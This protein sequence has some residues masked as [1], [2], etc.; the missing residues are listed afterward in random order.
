MLNRVT[1]LGLT[2]TAGDAEL[3]EIDAFFR[4]HGVRYAVALSP[5]APTEIGGR[6][7]ARGFE[8]GYAWAKFRRGVEDPE[9]VPTELRVEA[10]TDGVLFGAVVTAAYEMPATGAAWFA[11]LPEREGWHC[12]VAFDGDEPAGAG[13]LFVRGSV[14]WLGVAG[15]APEH[16]RKGAQNAIMATRIRRGRELGVT[17]LTTETGE[18]V[19]DRPSN[20]YRNILRT[21]FELRYVR[22]NLVS[23]DRPAATGPVDASPRPTSR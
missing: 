2:G 22:P 6:L 15:T 4:L 21:G 8:Y 12:F 11:S 14:G 9:P 3:D 13:A 16:R 10:V 18:L 1:G 7:Q 17:T 20:S 5:F 19:E 23:P